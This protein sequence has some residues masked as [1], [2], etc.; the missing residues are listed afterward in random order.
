MLGAVLNLGS[1]FLDIAKQVYPDSKDIQSAANVAGTVRHSYNVVNTTSVHQSANQALIAPMVAIESGLVQQD[2][3][4]DLMQ[5]VSLRDIVATLTHLSLQNSLGMGVKVEN[6]LGQI[7]PNRTGM[8]AL[9]GCEAFDTG[10]RKPEEKQPEQVVT[11]GKGIQDLH[12]YG[13]LAVGKVVMATLNNENG[14]KVEFP[15][16]FRQIPVPM[17]MSDFSLVFSAAR[18][19][20]GFK[21]RLMMLKTHEIT[22]PELLTGKDIVKQRFRI[23]NEEMAGYYKEATRRETNNRAQAI[24]TGIVSM[25]TLAN[26]FILSQDAANQIE[27]QIGKRFAN[28]NSR[29]EI[30]KAVKANTIVICNSDRG[31]FTFYTNGNDIPEIYTRN[32]ISVKAKKDTGTNNL[33]DLVKILNGG[34]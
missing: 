23:K 18:A 26:T 14:G 10:I 29:K 27:L 4:S 5:I 20:D 21:A 15:L 13:P 22:S 12:E 7:N 6:V 31:T 19:E 34:M 8:L 24:R 3:M 30:F 25:N 1:F 32:Q 16:T 11:S 9:A 28:N 33:A 2:Y 17:P